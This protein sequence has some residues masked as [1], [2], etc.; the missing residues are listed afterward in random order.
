M[1]FPVS[2]R[3]VEGVRRGSSVASTKQRLAVFSSRARQS[4]SW[5]NVILF[6]LMLLSTV[7]IIVLMWHYAQLFQEAVDVGGQEDG[8]SGVVN[9]RKM[10]RSGVRMVHPHRNHKSRLVRV[11]SD[12]PI[13]DVPGTPHPAGPIEATPLGEP[14]FDGSDADMRFRSNLETIKG[15]MIDFAKEI[16]EAHQAV[17]ERDREEG[18]HVPTTYGATVQC[19]CSGQYQQLCEKAFTGVRT[20]GVRLDVVRAEHQEAATANP[21]LN[22]KTTSASDKFLFGT[23]NEIIRRIGEH[24]NRMNQLSASQ[25]LALPRQYRGQ[26]DS[27]VQTIEDYAKWF[28]SYHQAVGGGTVMNHEEHERLEGCYVPT[29]Q[30]VITG[31]VPEHTLRPDFNIVCAAHASHG[32]DDALVEVALERTNLRGLAKPNPA[33]AL[34]TLSAETKKRFASDAVRRMAH[35]ATH[36]YF[37][38]DPAVDS[39]LLDAPPV[40]GD[41]HSLSMESWATFNKASGHGM[42]FPMDLL[43]S[44]GT[45]EREEEGGIPM[46]GGEGDCTV[47]VVRAE[48]PPEEVVDDNNE[49]YIPDVQNAYLSASVRIGCGAIPTDAAKRDHCLA[50]ADHIKQ[51]SSK[52]PKTTLVPGLLPPVCSMVTNSNSGSLSIRKILKMGTK[53][54]VYK[55]SLRAGGGATHDVLVKHFSLSQYAQFTGFSSF[56]NTTTRHPLILTPHAVCYDPPTHSVFQLQPFIPN[57]I[58][59]GDFVQKLKIEKRLDTDLTWPRRIEIAMQISCIYQ[60]LHREHPNGVFTF[61]DNH[62]Q[63]Y[64]LQRR[65]NT[66]ES[67]IDVRLVDIDTLQLARQKKDV[68]GAAAGMDLPLTTF[69]T[70]CRCF[71]CK[72]R[73]NCVFINTVE[74]YSE[75]GQRPEFPK[76]ADSEVEAKSHIASSTMADADGIVRGCDATTDV[77]FQAQLLLYLVRGDLAFS[78][79]SMGEVIL[80]L[81][82]GHLPAAQSGDAEYDSLVTDM[83]K[84]QVD[85][86]TGILPRLMRLCKKYDCGVQTCPV[87]GTADPKMVYSD[88]ML[89]ATP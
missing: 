78:A 83:F 19:S 59:L 48:D 27:P 72:G 38:I 16:L 56:M 11:L 65:S 69:K 61:D 66:P 21:S 40:K 63:Q 43:S 22:K 33:R 49:R 6:T 53:T 29:L 86:K 80:Q 35:Y 45:T 58:S 67:P 50:P 68:D 5:D 18:Y 39:L 71:F 84:R 51:I 14:N 20:G 52:R 15:D 10:I 62:P 31:S 76:T 44:I 81:Q 75:C 55:G 82:K 47:T 28:V 4:L 32:I 89:A 88:I 57:P 42:Y 26:E 2:R 46:G 41:P 36:T 77:W 1:N 37:M 9:V 12:A 7:T 87:V 85:E 30:Q 25:H 79:Q 13:D 17:P 73:S 3:E 24:A 54:G 34:S 64:V 23:N 74:G 8:N 60:F 70:R